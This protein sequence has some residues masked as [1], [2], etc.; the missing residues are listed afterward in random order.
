M[1]KNLWQKDRESLFRDLVQQYRD[2]GY[3]QQGC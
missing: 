2:E 3:D 1:T